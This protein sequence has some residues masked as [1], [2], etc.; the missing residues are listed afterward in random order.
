MQIDHTCTEASCIRRPGQ[1]DFYQ[2]IFDALLMVLRSFGRERDPE[3]IPPPPPPPRSR[4]F[5]RVKEQGRVSVTAAKA[6]VSGSTAS[7]P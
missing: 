6:R 1:I 2:S 5:S 3:F 7:R 4:L